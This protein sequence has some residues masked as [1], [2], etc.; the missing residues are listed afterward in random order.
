MR[1]V[2]FSIIKNRSDID[3]VDLSKILTVEKFTLV[4]KFNEI[5]FFAKILVFM[6]N[7]F[8]DIQAD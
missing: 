3:G 5:Q 1:K 8:V 6:A 2:F 4:D 7:K